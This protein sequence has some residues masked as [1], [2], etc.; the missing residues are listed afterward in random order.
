VFDVAADVLG[1]VRK[2]KS[3]AKVSLATP[4][5]RVVVRDTEARLAALALAGPDVV[6]AG[7]IDELVTEAA[8]ELS[9]TVT[10]GVAG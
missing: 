4:A 10:L 7:K 5:T 8:A 3:E 1:A 6:A 2:A 9:V